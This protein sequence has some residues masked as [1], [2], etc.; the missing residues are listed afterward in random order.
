MWDS[1]STSSPIF[2]LNICR[3]CVRTGAWGAWQAQILADQ[4]TIFKPGGLVMPK[5]L[6]FGTHCSKNA[7]QALIWIMIFLLVILFLITYLIT[8]WLTVI[9]VNC[10][11]QLFW[12]S[13]K[14]KY[15]DN[16]STKYIMDQ[17]YTIYDKRPC[18]NIVWHVTQYFWYVPYLETV[19]LSWLVFLV[20]NCVFIKKMSSEHHILQA[21]WSNQSLN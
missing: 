20:W 9:S 4:S 5:I 17:R 3:A 14:K 19:S 6:L 13:K 10:K 18:K 8:S 11:H 15:L 21:C 2:K 12:N 1:S 16:F 7:K